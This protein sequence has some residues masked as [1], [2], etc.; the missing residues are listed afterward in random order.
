MATITTDPVEIWPDNP[1]GM[2]RN[3]CRVWGLAAPVE[4]MPFRHLRYGNLA[5]LARL[6]DG[7]YYLLTH[8]PIS[9]QAGAICNRE[10]TPAE[11]A[12]IEKWRG[13]EA[14]TETEVAAALGRKGGSVRSPRKA[15]AS[16]AN[17]RKGGRPRKA[18]KRNAD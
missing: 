13:V 9:E 5:L 7:G 4:F 14:V 18:T 8:A 15:A 16:R 10:R 1:E 6:E 12:F 17:G 2:I 11:L 3:G